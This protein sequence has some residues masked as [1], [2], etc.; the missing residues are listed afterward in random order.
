MK[1]LLRA[2][3]MVFSLL[4]GLASA[5]QT[6]PMRPVTIVV[7]YPPGGSTD[8]LA[9][10]IGERLQ[11]AM[12]QPFVIANRAGAGGLI[13]TQSV[14]AA[15]P[16][17]YTLLLSSS[18]PLAVGLKM[19]K[20]VPYDVARDLTPIATLAEYTIVFAASNYFKPSSL[21]EVISYAKSNP[22]RLNIGLN[23]P[24][25]IHHLL[26]ELFHRRT[27]TSVNIVP[28]K[29]SGPLLIDLL[30]GV[31]DVDFDN[32]PVFKEHLRAGKLK[33]LA[34][35]SAKR[36]SFLPDVPTFAELGLPDLVAS[37]WNMLLA[38]SGTPEAIITRLNGEVNRILA[39]PEML[40]TMTKQGMSA[41]PNSPGHARK[42][43]L[44]EIDR[45]ARVV[46]ETG[47]RVE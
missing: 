47:T 33:A 7:P 23:S 10:L 28:Y 9:R 8:I 13:G 37:P 11:K 22:G 19:Y 42:F 36:S 24:G 12:G 29:G 35:A 31:V 15:P 2:M 21:D 16:D 25:S 41:M 20:R 34:V 26:T 38:P 43:L 40:E 17:G 30:A 46:D 3:T 1:A 4:A 18:P 39:S 32:L 27:S 14:A 45:W 6:Y 5:Q 44:E